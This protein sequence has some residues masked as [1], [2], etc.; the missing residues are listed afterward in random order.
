MLLYEAKLRHLDTVVGTERLCATEWLD[1]TEKV[2]LVG[3]KK[4]KGKMH[5]KVLAPRNE[6]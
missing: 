2:G 5:R 1:M 3:F 4:R 6:R